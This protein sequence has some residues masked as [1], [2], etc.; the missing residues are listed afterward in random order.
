[1]VITRGLSE[2]TRLGVAMG[3]DTATFSG[4]AGMGD[5]MVTCISPHSRNRHVGEE[6]GKGR[7]LDDILG[8]MTMV[9]EGVKTASL[10]MELAERHQLELPICA[11]IHGIVTGSQTVLDAYEGLMRSAPGHEAEPG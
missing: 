11:R 6:L 2:L 10:V 5:L 8:E 4:L 1:M 9:A 7:P 3:G